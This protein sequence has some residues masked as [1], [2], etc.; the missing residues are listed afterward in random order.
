VS[1][2]TFTGCWATVGLLKHTAAHPRSATPAILNEIEVRD[3]IAIAF[4]RL[5]T[6]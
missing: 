3:S 4:Q 2:V 1:T 5:K 6:T